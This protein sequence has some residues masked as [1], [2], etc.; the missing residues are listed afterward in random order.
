MEEVSENKK[1]K[2]DNLMDMK[3]RKMNCSNNKTTTKLKSP[4]NVHHYSPYKA[5]LNIDLVK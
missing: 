4:V 2:Q 3:G 1:G 5:M